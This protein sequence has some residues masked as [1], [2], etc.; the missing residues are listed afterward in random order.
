MGF[1]GS[2]QPLKSLE[3]LPKARVPVLSQDAAR[4]GIC[5]SIWPK[6]AGCKNV[7]RRGHQ[8]NYTFNLPVRNSTR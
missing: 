7:R 3:T 4:G 1:A 2:G 5:L 6:T 8:W